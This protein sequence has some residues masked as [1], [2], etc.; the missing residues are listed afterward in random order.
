MHH[1]RVQ[2]RHRMLQGSKAGI[3]GAPQFA[4]P[5]LDWLA[6]FSESLREHKACKGSGHERES[7]VC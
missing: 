7:E 5:S 6:A 1:A 2:D 3:S 4:H